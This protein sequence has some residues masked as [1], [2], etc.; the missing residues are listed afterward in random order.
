M[1]DRDGATPE[2]TS[3]LEEH[4]LTAVRLAKV[5]AMRSAGLDP[6]PTRFERTA[7]AAEIRSEHSGMAPGENSGIEVAVAGRIMNVRDMGKLAFA[8]LRDWSGDIQLFTTAA[9]DGFESFGA[10]DAGDW[11]GVTGEVMTTR[12]GELSVRVRELTM[13]AKGLRPL[14][15]KWHG[16]Q[17]VEQRHR[18]RYVDLI[19]NEESRE[20]LRL[21]SAVVRGLRDAFERRGFIEVETPI[22]QAV[23]G[24]GLAKPFE[25]HHNALDMDMYLR[26]ATELHLKRL[27]VGGVDKVFEIGRIFRNEGV[28]PRHNPEFTM[29]EA[30]WSLADYTDVMELVEKAIAE[31]AEEVLGTTLVEYGGVSLDLTPPWPRRGLFEI[32][33]ETTGVEWDLD[34]PIDTARALAL[35]HGVEAQPSWGVG[36]I[37]MEVFEEQVE[38]S[39]SGP[40]FVVDYPAEVS[41]LAKSRSDDPRLVERFEAFVGGWELGNAYSELNDPVEQRRR[42]EAQARARALG[43]DEAHPIDEDF[44]KALEYGMP[45]TGGLGIGVDRL[46]M[47]LTGQASIREVVLFPHLRP[48]G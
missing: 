35:E 34:M 5:E 47:L 11:V 13:L 2:G 16:L 32:T 1:S 20:V 15:E 41:P 43:D 40:I 46:I 37:V 19:V 48:E 8:V 17:D 30:Y 4:R 25:T 9:D 12:R 22:L 44:L 14:P 6:Y 33:S 7:V 45:P 31:V 21:R 28:S 38:A 24:G 10:L 26:I 18:M 42:F 3:D 39:L 27:I 23:P 29:L 36:K